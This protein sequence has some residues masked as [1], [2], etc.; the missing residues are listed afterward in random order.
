MKRTHTFSGSLRIVRLDLAT[1]FRSTFPSAVV[2]LASYTGLYMI[3]ALLTG[4]G[5]SVP[6]RNVIIFL[7]CLLLSI[8][9]PSSAFGS[10]NGDRN[11][12]LGILLPVSRG[13]KF[14]S[15]ILA[16]SLVAPAALFLSLHCCDLIL[17]VCFGHRAAISAGAA[18]AAEDFLMLPLVQSVFVYGNIVFRKRKI[19][20]PIALLCIVLGVLA[21]VSYIP[22][23]T[24]GALQAAITMALLYILPVGMYLLAYTKFIKLEL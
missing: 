2:L 19:L 18:E 8:T 22:D 9:V 12:L 11:S 5:L 15:M 21:G 20:Y 4:K 13:V 1:T 23:P 3:A 17:S 16:G 7:H 24:E 6:D 10:V 14:L